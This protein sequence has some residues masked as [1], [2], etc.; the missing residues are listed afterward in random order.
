MTTSHKEPTLVHSIEPT[1]EVFAA[2][3]RTL[4]LLA[5]PT[6][7]ELLWRLTEREMGVGE[8]VERVGVSRTVVSQ[9]LGK[10]RLGGLV[11]SRRE[12]RA[13]FYRIVDGHLKRL[14]LE[15]MNHADHQSS[16]EPSHV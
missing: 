8:L 11:S 1:E 6:R 5:E 12:G 7:L 15:A 13:V 9:H 10:L 3:T 16:G 14:V 2:G 4:K